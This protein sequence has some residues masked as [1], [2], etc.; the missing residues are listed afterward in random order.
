MVLPLKSVQVL[1]SLNCC[2]FTLVELDNGHLLQ[3]DSIEV[4]SDRLV[5]IKMLAAP[6]NPADIN[7][8]Q[9]VY[10]MEGE[11]AVKIGGNEGVGVVVATAPGSQLQ[12]GQWVV[13][14]RK[15]FG[16]WREQVICL[17]EDVQVIPSDIPL[18]AA[19]G[20]IVNP[21]TAYRMLQDFVNLQPG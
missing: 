6:V 8:V 1:P 5:W 14:G 18:P 20:F 4:S 15:A 17:D 13:P 2:N 21:P 3:R 16:T 7:Q 9:G 12:A 11:D 10:P 19:A